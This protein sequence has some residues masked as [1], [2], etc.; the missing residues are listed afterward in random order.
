MRRRAVSVFSEGGRGVYSRFG[1]NGLWE[2]GRSA[3][4]K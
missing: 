4:E 2:V 3:I 1:E